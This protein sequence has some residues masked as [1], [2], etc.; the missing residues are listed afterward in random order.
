[1]KFFAADKKQL[2]LILSLIFYSLSNAMMLRAG[3]LGSGGF[4]FSAWW[5]IATVSG[6]GIWHAFPE[7]GPRKTAAFILFFS[8]LIRIPYLFFFA[9]GDDIYRYLWEG[10]IQGH[11]FS[12]FVL[13]P[14]SPALAHLRDEFWVGINGKS[15]PAIYP[16]LAQILFRVLDCIHHSVL[17]FKAFFVFCD[18]MTT[19]VLLLWS[20]QKKYELRH[21][22][23]FALSQVSLIF[24]AGEGHLD[25]VM[26]AFLAGG[27]FLYDTGRFKSGFFLLGCAVMLKITPILLIPFLIT[28]K[29][30]RH[31]WTAAVPFL[32]IFMVEGNFI[33]V[34]VWFAGSTWYNGPL[35]W[36]L[37]KIHLGSAPLVA[38]AV[39]GLW[40]LREFFFG[41][42]RLRSAHI[43]MGLFFLCTMVLHPWYLL[44]GVM[45]LVFFRSP[46]LIALTASVCLTFTVNDINRRLGVWEISDAIVLAEYI[47]VLIVFLFTIYRHH[48]TGRNSFD[49]PQTAAV[50]IPAINEE[51]TIAACIRSILS[52]TRVPDEIWIAD[53][54]ST[55]E[56]ITIASAFPGLRV[57]RSAPGRGIQIARA[58]ESSGA[59]M[60]LI[61]HADVQPPPTMVEEAMTVL[62]EN[63]TL[64]GG[65]FRVRYD[66][67]SFKAAVISW[68][69]FLKTALLGIS[70]GDQCQF[71][72]R[73]ALPFGFPAMWLMEDAELS[74]RIR[75]AGDFRY[76]LSGPVVSFRRWKKKGIAANFTTILSL[77]LRFVIFRRLGLLSDN[78]KAFYQHYYGQ[79][80][81][82]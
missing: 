81:R 37:R 22:L 14:D 44:W 47:P 80:E 63:R 76:L 61:C 11:G 41:A 70:F 13:A 9:E 39:F 68:I 49:P 31:L 56:T 79:N 30:I 34:L 1:M 20:H 27:L 60:I 28:R 12:P 29:N 15:I 66:E 58:L 35:T 24:S 33:A 16:P 77:T 5:I 48:S 26:V 18:C 40:A 19:A 51:T 25:A 43:L 10:M 46:T 65:A 45:L 62:S 74:F 36:I 17:T 3:H 50:I 59:D 67:P 21:V 71:F 4:F 57:V 38:G 7:A 54:G 55:D 53:G 82:P 64:A 6:L 8:I 75:E 32:S 69:N 73:A 23:L 2:L 72:Q 52:Q 78:A 42:D